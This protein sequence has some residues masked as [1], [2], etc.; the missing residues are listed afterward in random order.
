MS[1]LSLLLRIR[2]ISSPEARKIRKRRGDLILM[3]LH[4]LNLERKNGNASSH[5]V[6]VA[7]TI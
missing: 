7:G 4:L 1:L 3:L 5:V 2:E 6:H